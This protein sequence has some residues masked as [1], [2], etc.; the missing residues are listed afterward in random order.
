MNDPLMC[1]NER[2]RITIFTH[3]SGRYTAVKVI[4]HDYGP[5]L[6]LIARNDPRLIVKMGG[7]NAWGGRACE[8]VYQET[9]Y[10]ALDITDDNDGLYRVV[11]VSSILAGRNRRVLK[12]WL[13]AWTK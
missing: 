4:G 2:R 3:H 12:E 5:N 13:R 6:Q 10:W 7:Y 8:R 1:V 9:E 11:C